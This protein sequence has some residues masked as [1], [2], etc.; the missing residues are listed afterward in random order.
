MFHVLPLFLKLPYLASPTVGV[1]QGE[2]AWPSSVPC[3]TLFWVLPPALHRLHTAICP[4]SELGVDE[5]LMYRSQTP[6]CL[7]LQNNEMP[8]RK[9]SA[10]QIEHMRGGWGCLGFQVA[11][12][13]RVKRKEAGCGK[14]NRSKACQLALF[15]AMADVSFKTIL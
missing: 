4:C 1:W 6:E 13:R 15:Y 14:A 12:A 8:V 9:L 7:S 5:S 3:G 2:T 11:M 10:W